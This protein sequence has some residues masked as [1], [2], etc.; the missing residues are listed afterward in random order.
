MRVNPEVLRAELGALQQ[1]IR[2][3]EAQVVKG[4]KLAPSGE[5]YAALLMSYYQLQSHLQERI[6]Q[7]AAESGN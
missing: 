7:C 1:Q 3:A 4:V 6:A 2:T 5:S